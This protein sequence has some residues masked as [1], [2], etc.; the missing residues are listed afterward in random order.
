MDSRL[1]GQRAATGLYP[2]RR[3]QR[4]SDEDHPAP[5]GFRESGIIFPFEKIVREKYNGAKD[6]DVKVFLIVARK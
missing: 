6:F 3:V 4:R 2:R 5:V 1:D